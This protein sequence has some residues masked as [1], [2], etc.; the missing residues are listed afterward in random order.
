MVSRMPESPIARLRLIGL[1]EGTSFL[2][3]L[4]VA[5]PLKHAFGMPMAVKVA[6]WAHGAL[7]IAFVLALPGAVMHARWSVG[8]AALLFMSALVPGGP[9]F[10]DRKLREAD[11]AAK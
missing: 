9:F 10:M 8:R 5:M 6:G 7:F 11:A 1:L 3:L 2:L 4:L